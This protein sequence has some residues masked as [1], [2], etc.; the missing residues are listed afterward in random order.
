MAGTIILFLGTT[1]NYILQNY[2]IFK[3]LAYETSPNL[4]M[5]LDREVTWFLLFLGVSIFAVSGLAFYIGYKMT[6]GILKPIIH[7]ERHMTKVIRGDWAN[8]DF[9]FS[10]SE[11]LAD[12]FATYS[13]L[14]R[15]IRAQAQTEVKL[16]EKLVIDPNNREA[17]TIWK[18]LV[19]MKRTQLNIS[20]KINPI[21]ENVPGISESDDFRR[22]S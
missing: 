11:D 3:K 2:G 20:E 1:T 15:T 17:M 9:R 6:M 21:I 14:Y 5:Y 7:M 16:L 18:Q 12:F 13:Y 8:E 4:V 10:K 22:V 19:E